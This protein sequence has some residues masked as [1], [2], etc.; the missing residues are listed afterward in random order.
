M[1]KTQKEK[2]L[3]QAIE[4]AIGKSGIKD[5]KTIWNI[6]EKIQEYVQ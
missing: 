4:T 5:N 2:E 3:Q 1:V 6:L